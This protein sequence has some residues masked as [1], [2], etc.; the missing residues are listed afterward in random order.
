M[1]DGGSLTIATRN[2]VCGPQANPMVLIEVRDTGTGI[3]ERTKQHIF[4]PFYTTKRGSK[5]TG[6]G[7]ATVFGIVTQAGGE[8]DVTSCVGEG[9]TF[10]VRLPRIDGRQAP[11]A[12]RTEEEGQYRGFG[13]VLVV[14]DQEEVR[15]LACQIVEELGF[16][17]LSAANGQEALA[18]VAQISAPIR[19][20]LTDVVMP[21]MD[22]GELAERITA[23]Q[24]EM[25]VIFMSGYPGQVLGGLNRISR[26]ISFLQK[27][28]TRAR[29]IG[30]LRTVLP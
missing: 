22:G 23:A 11:S 25:R 17:V 16:Q 19:L 20:L 26:P 6:L 12:A 1:P 5:G 4:E 8:I 9:S 29:L 14:E 18:T 28:F 21:G 2:V 7:L 27:P 3:D 10:R 13:T 24:P 15:R 30:L